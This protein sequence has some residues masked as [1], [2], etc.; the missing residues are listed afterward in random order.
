[1]TQGTQAVETN[2]S[3]AW[4]RSRVGAF[5]SQPVS[6]V[7]LIVG[8][9]IAFLS[10]YPTFFLFYGSLTD[11]PLGVPGKFTLQNYVR[12]YTDPEAYPLLLNSF[13]FG[14]GAS[15]LS[16]IFA[17][18][19]AWITIR[20]NAP[21]RRVFELTAIVPNILPPILVSISWVMLLN[22][23]NGLINAGL[24][25]VLGIEKGP[26]NIYSM[27]GLIFVEGLILTPLA[28]LII[29]A[30]MKSMDPSLEES[31]KTLGSNEFGIMRR[32][33]FPLLRP[34]ILAAATLNLVRAIESFDTP[35]IIALPARIE[36]FTTK[37]WREALG[38]FPTNHNLAAA[39]GVGI[40]GIALVFVYLYRRFTSQVESFST[41]TGKG[42]RP[43]QIDLGR[44]RYAASG[45]ALLLLVLL[46]VLPI[47]VL[48]LVAILPYYHV[49]TWQTWQNLTL[50][51][52]RYVWE[53]A[54]VHKAFMN[55]LFLALVGATACMVLA[56]L[57]SYITVRS[58]I[59]GRS[60]IEGLV[61][62]P[63]AF[64]GTAMALGLLWAYVDFPIPVYATIWII[65]IAYVTRF[66]PYG[67]RAVTST[68]I[69][70]HKELEEASIV[71][72]AG[73]M[74][75]FRRVLIPMMRPGV[76]AGW[77]ILVTIFM[78]E[79]SATLF[80]YSP[81]AEPLGP[82]LYFLYLDGMRGRVA[83]I[84]LV[85]SVI[86]IILIA[87]AQRYSRWDTK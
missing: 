42:F 40:L 52:F 46:V 85:I 15:G 53:T 66:L 13:I 79:F 2:V 5:L 32:I 9:I 26:F 65:L 69:Q 8:G 43:H 57:A 31:A 50:D 6:W 87:I 23:S 68:I 38:S 12:A 3:T 39:Y 44:W 72:G 77:I 81:G 41:V 60:I 19:L 80:L 27:A 4:T 59:A 49:P 73:F 7:F 29:A 48:I 25:Q 78:R 71:C 82:L 30:A 47:L 61:F 20:T 75:T 83:A 11:A 62:I 74:A 33:T 55:S 17:L 34:A 22:P 36:V 84:G 10:L 56:S 51:N 86:S 54:R 35:A 67:L 18:T 1:M 28:F 63:W 21:Y 58:K 70:I 45:V 37:I 24:V 76:M 14:I 16:I 64:P